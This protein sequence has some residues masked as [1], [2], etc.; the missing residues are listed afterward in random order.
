MLSLQER[1]AVRGW[2]GSA[3]NCEPLWS[4]GRTSGTEIAWT[5]R[6]EGKRERATPFGQRADHIS[7]DAAAF[8]G[9][10][11]GYKVWS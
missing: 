10:F 8:A 2:W 4:W 5:E 7:T 1:A 6:P 3:G 9:L 11:A